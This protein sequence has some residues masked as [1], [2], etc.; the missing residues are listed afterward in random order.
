M[1]A[2]QEPPVARSV[3]SPEIE[4]EWPGVTRMPVARGHP[5][6]RIALAGGDRG[7]PVER[8][9]HGVVAVEEKRAGSY[10]RIHAKN[11]VLEFDF[12]RRL[13]PHA[14]LA[15]DVRAGERVVRRVR[16]VEVQA[17]PI[18]PALALESRD[19]DA[20]RSP[21][22]RV[23]IG[24]RND[25][26]V[27][28]AAFADVHDETVVAIRKPDVD[29]AAIVGIEV[30]VAVGSDIC[31]V[32]PLQGDAGVGIEAGDGHAVAGAV[33][34][35]GD[36]VSTAPIPIPASPGDTATVPPEIDTKPACALPAPP[37]PAP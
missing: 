1:P 36:D 11:Q 26:A 25:G 24:A 19:I 20:V 4:S 32:E 2:A 29:L 3:P 27:G 22:G 28:F 18:L 35:G 13:H 33:V 8:H 10:V 37:M 30:V 5:D 23:D 7:F 17:I 21:D 16:E 6:A 14:H 31:V 34:V 12:A 15:L 9:R